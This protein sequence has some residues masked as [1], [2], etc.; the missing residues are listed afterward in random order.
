MLFAPFFV[1]LSWGWLNE[2]TK[3][4]TLIGIPPI[5]RQTHVVFKVDLSSLR[6]FS[7]LRDSRGLVWNMLICPRKGNVT[8]F[9]RPCSVGNDRLGE[10][11]AV[12]KPG[13]G[14]M[15][16]LSFLLPSKSSKRLSFA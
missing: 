12:S 7:G 16:A 11:A 3:G 5:V 14:L 9:S 2:T 10:Q 15:G 4:K 1:G 13:D 8:F 6:S